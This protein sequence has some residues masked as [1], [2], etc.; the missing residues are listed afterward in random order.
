MSHVAFVIPTLDRVAG[1]ERQVLDLA[2]GLAH[3]HWQISVV[4]LSGNGGDA[5][6]QLR[7]KGISFLSLGMRKQHGLTATPGTVSRP[8]PLS[9]NVRPSAA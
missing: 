2:S 7:H 4:A 8:G 6:H 5:A 3:R 1:A 9:H